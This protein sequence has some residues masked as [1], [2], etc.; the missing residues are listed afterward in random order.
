MPT[1]HV[2]SLASDASAAETTLRAVA[3][4]VAEVTPCSVSAV[5]V[6]FA[7]LEVQTIGERV[8]VDDSRIVYVDLWMRRRPEDPE[9]P[10][11][12]L[13]AACGAAAAGVGVPVED[14]W[15]TVRLVEPGR[16]FAGGALVE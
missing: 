10:A 9:A 12:A 3:R 6:T 16:V 2:R 13:A 5:W 14:V 4:A 8:V 11:R 15:G 7:A 1:V